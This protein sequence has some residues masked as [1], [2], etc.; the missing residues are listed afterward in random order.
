MSPFPDSLRH[1]AAR[2][3]RSWRLA[4]AIS[5]MSTAVAAITARLDS[6]DWLGLRSADQSMY[7]RGL[8]RFTLHPRRSDDVVIVAVDD[9]TLQ[10]VAASPG[11]R[12][13]YGNWPYFRT[14]WL[15]LA[16]HLAAEGARAVVLDFTFD[17]P[18]SDASG[19]TLLGEGLAR[20]RLPVYVGVATSLSGRRLP[21]I[22]PRNLFPA[23][24][25]P[26][27]D[28]VAA[29]TDEFVDTPEAPPPTQEELARAVAFPVRAEGGLRLKELR[30]DRDRNDALRMVEPLPPA[31]ALLPG[32]AGAGLVE[33]EADGD[34]KMRR[35]WFAY[36]DGANTFAT[37]S[38]AAAADLLGAR[39]LRLSP[40]RLHLGPRELRVNADGSAEIDYGGSL[41]ERFPRYTFFDVLNDRALKAE[42]KPR[43]L[44]EGAFRGKVVLVGG[45]AAGLAD[46]KATPFSASVPGVVKHAAELD[47]LL[48][49]QFIVQAAPGVSVLLA[50][51]VAALSAALV[52]GARSILVEIAWPVLLYAG[53]FAVTGAILSTTKVHVDAAMGM[54]AGMVA[55]LSA[56]AANHLFANRERERMKQMFERYLSPAVV[57]QLSDQP[58]LPKL[59]GEAVEITAFFSDIKGFSTFSEKYRD[60]P[61]GLVQIL[62]TYLTRV[63]AALLQHGACLDK[64]IGDAV[65]CIFGAPV[66]HPDHALRACRGALAAREEVERIR[67]EFKEKGLPDVYTRIGVNTAVMFVGNVGSEQLFNYTAIGDGM[68]L[69]ARLE[70]AN[71]SYETAIMIGPRT[72]ELARDFIEVRE[73]DRVRVAGK[74]E[75]VTVYELLCLKGDLQDPRR[76]L[77]RLY[78]QALGRYREERFDDALQLL[79]RA[80]AVDP[81]DGPSRALAAR[82]HKYRAR[83]PGTP[84]D[85]VTSL[86]K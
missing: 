36:T 69:A 80:L 13:A 26:P 1:L 16:E 52:L 40:G 70:G 46:V 19:D 61:G 9:R 30:R 66:R 47:A 74:T 84:F 5:L 65:V 76:E 6:G 45:F 49:G 67:A 34:G 86:E 33:P 15:H 43:Y 25:T 63:S 48:H 75:P 85:P 24:L 28:Q 12:Q 7:D 8:T 73:L 20:G 38:V 55:S 50:L 31:A 62:N 58:D 4:A 3:R 39:E 72:C 18:A 59:T 27:A 2:A 23:E 21:K 71:K 41:E 22:E 81:A 17:E 29:A 54:A 57:E 79:E 11:L 64:Y 53:F 37:L 78:E 56:I 10:M 60:D 14:A 77:V 35:T 82:C 44:P 83:P 42:G 32:L 68:N 51:L